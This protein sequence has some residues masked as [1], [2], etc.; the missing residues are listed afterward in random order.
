MPPTA[1]LPA[2]VF[3]RYAGRGG[4]KPLS[5]ATVSGKV[6]VSVNAARASG[7]A[8]YLDDP[9]MARPAYSIDTK[10]PYD[11]AGTLSNGY[12]RLYW[13]TKLRNGNHTLTIRVSFADG[14][15]V[16]ETVSFQVRN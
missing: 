8:F 7:V 1:G 11:L 14:T 9:G 13:T 5:R 4:S 3:S 2:I 10:G 16:T 15:S 12:A 6:Y